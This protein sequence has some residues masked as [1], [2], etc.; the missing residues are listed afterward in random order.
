[1]LLNDHGI[2]ISMDGTGRWRDNVFVE[3]LWRSLKYEEGYLHAY[4][5]V[6]NAQEGVNRYMTLYHEIRPHRALDGR[7]PDRVYCD[8]LPARP[9]AA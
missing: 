2:Q 5:T 6:R 3:R 8:N 4:E 9:I 1:G 7:T